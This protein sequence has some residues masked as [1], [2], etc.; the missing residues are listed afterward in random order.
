MSN[1]KLQWPKLILPPA[2][3]LCTEC[4]S[5]QERT[6]TN[7]VMVVAYCVH[8]QAGGIMPIVDGVPSGR[9]TII[10]PIGA[11]DFADYANNLAARADEMV[12]LMAKS[13]IQN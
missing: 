5:N 6:A 4:I 11:E 7:G 3:G 2:G 10:T 8:T 12:R 9:W 1:E 13:R